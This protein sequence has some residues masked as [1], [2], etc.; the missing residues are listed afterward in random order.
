MYS[1][2]PDEV[3]KKASTFGREPVIG[4]IEEFKI[5]W[6]ASWTTPAWLKTN[7]PLVDGNWSYKDYAGN[8]VSLS[9]LKNGLR[10]ICGVLDDLC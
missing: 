5:G 3:Q 10:L 6:V 1:R 8:S 9:Q 4:A 2:I 7:E